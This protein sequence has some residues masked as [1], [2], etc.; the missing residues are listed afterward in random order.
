MWMRFSAKEPFALK[1]YVGGVNAISGVPINET[2]EAMQQRLKLADKIKQDYVV[3]PEQPWLDGIASEDGRIRQFVAMPKGSGY[4]VE[5]QVTGEE[6]IGG[7]QFEI[8]P[9]KRNCPATINV[10]LSGGNYR[11]HYGASNTEKL[12]NL[13]E[14]GLGD[15]STIMD[16]K[17]VIEKEFGIDISNQAL[18]LRQPS[19]TGVFSDIQN[20]GLAFSQFWI[21]EVCLLSLDISKLI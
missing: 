1:I 5:A 15:T 21:S 19:F 17:R 13:H 14:K 7:I 4:S 12:L 9:V 18:R 8:T 2:P 3:L 16:L 6:K 11:S 20:D 10:S